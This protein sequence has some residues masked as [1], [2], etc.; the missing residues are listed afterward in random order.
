MRSVHTVA[1]LAPRMGGPS[2]SVPALCR[3]LTEA[4]EQV[5]LVTGAGEVAQS[6]RDLESRILVRYAP[7]GPYAAAN[8]SLA[9]RR[10][11]D[12]ALAGADLLH[13]HGIWLDPNWASAVAARRR[14]VA[15][16]VSPRGMLAP[17]ALAA[18]RW[19]KRLAWAL[20]DGPHLRRA[21][22][23]HASSP[24]EARQ[25]RAAGVATPIA[26]IGNGVDTAALRPARDD[27][28]PAATRRR[29]YLLYLGR[30]H[31]IK[32]IDL[33]L[34]AWRRL[35][36][37]PRERPELLLAGPGEPRHLEWLRAELA[38]LGDP[39]VRHLGPVWGAEKLELLRSARVVVLPSRS[40]SFGMVVA[41]ALACGIPVL[42]T[43]AAPWGAIERER[44]GWWVEPSAEALSVALRAALGAQEEEIEAMGRRGR[45]LVQREH[46]LA[47]SA[48]RMIA[49]YAWVLGRGARPPFVLERNE[50][51]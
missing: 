10:A 25:V 33:L 36:D 1:R 4:G 14:R 19:R 5:T 46:S 31:P 45:G 13:T 3:A 11:L 6:V 43:T 29:S 30:V 17:R 22:L 21:A 18:G 40:E 32:G 9:F 23:V 41:E 49:A 8:F 7:L 47:A 37:S 2:A 28:A 20:L 38:R 26:V 15:F 44:C 34:E 42:A 24:E 12:E 39:R 27:G 50:A 48:A 35:G 51:T 16:V